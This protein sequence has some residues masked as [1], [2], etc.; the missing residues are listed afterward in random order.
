MVSRLPGLE[1]HLDAVGMAGDRLV[2]AVVEHLGGEMVQRPLVDAADI[3]A[4]A[5]ADRLQ[6][7]QHLDRMGVI[8]AAGLRAGRKQI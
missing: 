7:L 4:G 2:H 5:P 8:I 1:R 3:H 6:P